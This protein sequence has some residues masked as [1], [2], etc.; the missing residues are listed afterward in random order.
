M[1]HI[2]RYAATA[3]VAVLS[4][5]PARA[6]QAPSTPSQPQANTPL[7]KLVETIDVKVIGVDV[8]VTDKKGNII[9]GLTKDDFEIY[10]NNRAV[11][12]T[13]FYE[14]DG[15]KTRGGGPAVEPEPQPTTAAATPTRQEIPDNLKRRIIFYID[16]LSMAPFNRNRVFSQMKEFVKTSMRP[17]DEAMIA[18]F[19]RSM[20]VRVPFTKDPVQIQQTLDV[21]A[22]ESAL[23][24]SNRSERKDVEDRIRDAQDYTSAL[25]S[26]R[27]YASSVEHDLRT[28]VASINALMGTLAGVEGKKILVLTSEGFPMQPGREMFYFI[29]DVAKE[30]GWSQ[31]STM[32]EG[33]SFDAH[34]LIQD[35]AKTANANNITM[36]TIHAA[37]LSAG[38]EMS[39]ENDRP[40][41]FQVSQAA[42]SNTTDSML[43]MAD[44]TGGLASTQTNNFKEAFNKINR[45]LDSYYS[46]GYR[47][48]FER[49]D[50]QKNLEVKIKNK[51]YVARARTSFVEKSTF[52]EMSDRVIANLLYKTKENDLKILVKANPPRPADDDLFRVPIEVQIPMESLTFLPQG[53]NGY[54]G[55]FDVYVV[56]GDR[57]GDMS[58]VN[59]QSHQ[60]H[61]DADKLAATKGKY[62]SYELELLM[63]RGLNK[64][65]I[66]VV[67]EISNTS[68][69]AR[70]QILAQDLR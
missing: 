30:K 15:P 66:G 13:N 18:T 48:S 57:N 53:E 54:A 7:G 28:S 68:G 19:N 42:L 33:M 37:G 6:Q 40:V 22:G 3:A 1:R 32:L 21:I 14:V 10:E 41:S 4:L 39:A 60:I 25:A 47:G 52:A 17:G 8:V 26:A 29:D 65:S 62:Y 2:V 46:L 16:N 27:T 5:L 31:G 50:R 34:S 35:V 49:V 58:D 38:N 61:I 56:V 51:N 24:L 63:E 11:P 36:Y 20:K 70:E 44:M 55:G 9:K 12:I 64:I 69:F 23:G 59:R 45:D 43:M 67:D